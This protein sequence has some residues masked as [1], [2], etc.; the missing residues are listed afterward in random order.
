MNAVLFDIDG[1]LLQTGG[2]G[3]IAFAETFR[4]LFSIT[5]IAQ[6]VAFAGRSDRAIAYEL[7]NVHGIPSCDANWLAFVEAFLPRLHQ[8]LVDCEGSI[9]PGVIQLLDLLE[10]LEFVSVGLLTGNIAE[11]ARAKLSHYAIFDRFHFGG[12]GDDFFDRDDIAAAAFEAAASY[13][14]QNHNHKLEPQRVVVIGDTPA[15]V[16]CARAIGAIAVGVA[17][18]GASWE[19]LSATQPD[20]LLHDLNDPSEIAALLVGDQNGDAVA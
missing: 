1:T 7:M 14:R 11:G 5:E 6:E 17:T 8:S 20:V 10:E 15:D 9:L 2:A 16:K 18:G 19:E 4:E 13:V 12:F 3:R